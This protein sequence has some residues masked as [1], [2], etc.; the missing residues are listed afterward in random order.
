MESK[1]QKYNC[2][3]KQAVALMEGENNLV[4][5]LSNISALLHDSFPEN[6]WWAGFYFVKNDELILGPFQGPVACTHIKIGRGV[7]G[8]AWKEKR[9]ILVADVEKFPGHIACSTLSRSE[10]VVPVY[11][12]DKVWGVIDIDSTQRSAFDEKDQAGLESLAVVLSEKIKS[13][14]NF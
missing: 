9:T 8:T 13:I 3:L 12:A 6:F 10:I 5:V 7:C 14:P 11:V 4:S 1:S 2:M